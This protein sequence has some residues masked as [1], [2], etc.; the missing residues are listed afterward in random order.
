MTPGYKT[1]EFWLSLAS[2]G[3][4]L[5]AVVLGLSAQEAQ[6]LTQAVSQAVVAVGSI[7]TAG[8]TVWA[9]IQARTLLKVHTLDSDGDGLDDDLDLDDDNDGVLD[10]DE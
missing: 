7:V 5:V 2:T 8:M 3:V 6:G 10:A 1:T 9:Y 4:G